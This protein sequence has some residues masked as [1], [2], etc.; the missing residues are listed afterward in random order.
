[1]IELATLKRARCAHRFAHATQIGTTPTK[2]A[3]VHSTDT[4]TVPGPNHGQHPVH[5]HWPTEYDGQVLRCHS[6]VHP[7]PT[8]AFTKCPYPGRR[9]PG[10]RT[11]RMAS[12]RQRFSAAEHYCYNSLLAVLREETA[13]IVL[14]RNREASFLS[15]VP[16]FDFV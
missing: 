14:P 8:E 12:A 9:I 7:L 3:V 5:C 13:L 4:N 16:F 1:M 15:S 11:V 10:V 6:A 2:Y